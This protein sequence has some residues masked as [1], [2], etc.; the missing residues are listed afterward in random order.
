[1]AF[2]SQNAGDARQARIDEMETRMAAMQAMLQGGARGPINR[3]EGS[4]KAL[5]GVGS[6]FHGVHYRG[7]YDD[8]LHPYQFR[9]GGSCM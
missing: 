9:D 6:R 1:M 4:P 7:T 2:S 3:Q 5:A 8:G